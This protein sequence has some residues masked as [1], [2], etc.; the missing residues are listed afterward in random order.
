[1]DLVKGAFTQQNFCFNYKY[2][3]KGPGRFCGISPSESFIL[4]LGGAEQKEKTS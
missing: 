4:P 1:M 3:R 2:V